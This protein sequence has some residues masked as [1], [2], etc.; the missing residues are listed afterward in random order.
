MTPEELEREATIARLSTE[1][2]H[3]R[4]GPATDSLDRFEA[5]TRDAIARGDQET[6]TDN[7]SSLMATI[8]QLQRELEAERAAHQ[9]TVDD[10]KTIME[11][12][13]RY[14]RKL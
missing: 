12:A 10:A 1:L 5:A 9:Q 7:L 2:T 11:R 14:R 4:R 13:E 6:A 3:S 8:R